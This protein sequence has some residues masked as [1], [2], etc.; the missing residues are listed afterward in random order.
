[1]D[2]A[3]YPR[4]GMLPLT[5][6]I[7]LYYAL[8]HCCSIVWSFEIQVESLQGIQDFGLIGLVVTIGPHVREYWMG[9]ITSASPARKD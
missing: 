2:G 4:L 1:M 6:V 3:N 8:H 7:G 5:V 9:N